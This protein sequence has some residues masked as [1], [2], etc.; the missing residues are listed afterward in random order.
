MEERKLIKRQEKAVEKEALI[1]ST[2]ALADY[3]QQCGRFSEAVQQYGSLA[4]ICKNAG[5]PLEMAMAHRSCAECFVSMNQPEKALEQSQIYLANVQKLKNRLEEQRAQTTVGRAHLLM[6]DGSSSESS[7]KSLK[8]AERSFIKSLLICK[9]IAGQVSKFEQLEMQARLFINLSQVKE[10]SKCYEESMEYMEKAL[11][12]CKANDL[13]ELLHL[14][15]ISTSLLYLGKKELSS[16]MKLC[17]LAVETAERLPNK[18]KKMCES[19]IL[20]S[21]IL[22]KMGD[23]PG[24]KQILKRAYKMKTPDITDQTNIEKNLK[25]VVSLCRILDN[26]VYT[27]DNSEKKKLYE[28]LADGW[29]LFQNYEQAIEYY[30]KALECLEA[31]D[32]LEPSELAPMYV[33]LYQTYKDD[34]QY[35]KAVEYLW[36][37]YQLHNDNPIEAFETLCNIGDILET[38]KKPFWTIQDVFQKALILGK[39][40]GRKYMKKAFIRLHKLQIDSDMLTLAEE[41]KEEGKTFGI[42]LSEKDED[43]DSEDSLVNSEELHIDAIGADI[44][45]KDLSDSEVE[46]SD[47]EEVV[48]RESRLRRKTTA[49]TVKK[50]LKGETQLHKACIEGNLPLAKKL[51]EQ[52]HTINVRDHAGWLPLH[53]ACNN[54][55]CEIVELLLDKG[56]ISAIND[57]GCDGITPL[58]D[59]CSNGHLNIVSLLISRGAN[60]TVKTDSEETVLDGLHKWKQSN[61]N[62]TSSEALEYKSI[63]EQLEEKMKRVGINPTTSPQFRNSNSTLHRLIDDDNSE[64]STHEENLNATLVPRFR[65][66]SSSENLNSSILREKNK[67]Q[68]RSAKTEYQEAMESMKRPNRLITPTKKTP[69]FKKRKGYLG[70]SD[71]GDDWLE[72]DMEPDKKKRRYFSMTSSTEKQSPSKVCRAPADCL[73]SNLFPDDDEDSIDAFQVMLGSNKTQSKRKSLPRSLSISSTGSSSSGFSRKKQQTSLLESGFTRSESPISLFGD[74][75]E[76]DSTTVSVPSVNIPTVIPTIP[77]TVSFKVKVDNEML[78]V[79][80]DRKKI[81]ET[82]IRWLAEETSRRFYNSVGLKPILRLKTADGFAFEENDCLS[83]ALEQN[84]IS[85]EVIEYQMPPLPQRYLEMCQLLSTECLDDIKNE[86][87]KTQVSNTIVINDI[88]LTADITE[89]L[90]RSFSHQS[91]IQFLDLSNNFLQNEGCKQ[92]SKSLPTLKH[93]KSLNL[94]GNCIT[95]EG[96]DHL[97]KSELPELDEIILNQ[98]PLGNKSVKHFNRMGTVFTELKKLGISQCGLEDFYDYELKNFHKLQEFDLSFNPLSIESLK[99]ILSKLNSCRLVKLNL[100]FMS[101]AGIAQALKEFFESGTCDKFKDIALENCNLIDADVYCL[102]ESLKNATHLEVL[103]LS[104][105]LG[106]TEIGMQ[107]ITSRSPNLQ[108]LIL[109]EC[110]VESERLLTNNVVLPRFLQL[111]IKKDLEEIYSVT[112]S[113]KHKCDFRGSID[114]RCKTVTFTENV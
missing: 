85:S 94:S 61:L 16:A 71:V 48:V 84:I 8:N 104:G 89:P 91:V 36:K 20:K 28:R 102:M 45:L 44:D 108:K 74:D 63:K 38:Q 52:G 27:T 112:N 1:S 51:I 105:N 100:S 98:N 88:P 60:V 25:I 2:E 80:V 55:F 114:I 13:F 64:D 69:E 75:I 93:L 97:V 62:L 30:L 92:L 58:Y 17:N 15:Y 21:E 39:T 18:A 24:L 81:N 78:L 33:S 37:E 6:S 101:G 19:L 34:K 67:S 66:G 47:V 42:E 29:C 40:L 113:W 43:S 26:L 95:A 12:I 31:T 107:Y 73:R 11:K 77:T 50:N 57:K 14:C 82:T 79:P 90:F 59:A 68:R 7:M 87:E 96:L 46:D 49:F 54:G 10:Q 76:P 53:E 72:E 23:L 103:N 35:D 110:N 70:P 111:S 65:R 4:N 86:L 56:A 5:K 106:I 83:V 22:M 41:I 3:Y 99:T 32:N 109:N 9:E